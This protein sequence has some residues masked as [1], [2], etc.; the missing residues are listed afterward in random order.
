[1]V[2]A[3]SLD[4]NNLSEWAV[5]ELNGYSS[6]DLFPSYRVLSAG[7]IYYSGLNGN[8]KVKSIPFPLFSVSVLENA[9]KGKLTDLKRDLTFF[10]ADV[11]AD[12]GG[13]IQC[14]NIWAAIDY[15]KFDGVLSSLRTKILQLFISLDKEI[16]NLDNLDVDTRNT[17]L[18]EL[19]QIIFNVLYQDKSVNL[20]DKTKTVN[21]NSVNLRVNGDVTNSALA[22]SRG[23]ISQSLN[24]CDNSNEIAKI[25]CEMRTLVEGL[26]NDEIIGDV[27]DAIDQIEIELGKKEANEAKLT[28][29]MKRIEEALLPIKNV[30]TASTLLV[31]ANT[32]A[33]LIATMFGVS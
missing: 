26:C 2:I 31:H 21:D 14:T 20:E 28:R 24:I 3:S 29:A 32:L 18:K 1:M 6:D 22:A 19:R 23:Q 17:N 27:T 4:D 11:F 5:K 15:L 25:L 30:T 16:G 8:F 10:A 7:N 12:T 33:P 9:V 13:A